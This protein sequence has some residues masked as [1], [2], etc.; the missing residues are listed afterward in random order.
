MNALDDARNDIEDR[1][2]LTMDR[3]RQVRPEYRHAV[4]TLTEEQQ[5]E[6]DEAGRQ[7][8]AQAQQ[9]AVRRARALVPVLGG[10]TATNAQTAGRTLRTQVTEW[11]REGEWWGMEL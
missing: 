1:T 7:L 8:D 3:A 6:V 5:Q 9:E 2:R 10:D 11:G 4:V